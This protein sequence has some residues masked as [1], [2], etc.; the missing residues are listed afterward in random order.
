ML[1]SRQLAIGIASVVAF[2]AALF[3][4]SQAKAEHVSRSC[5]GGDVYVTY[6]R[7]YRTTV[8]YTEPVRR[9]SRSYLRHY[10]KPHRHYYSGHRRHLRPFLRSLVHHAR[11]RHGSH[12]P[13]FRSGRRHH[14]GHGFSFR[15]RR[16]HGGGF[17]RH[18]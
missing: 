8:V 7:A 15:G 6:G 2:A 10:R 9:Y 5:G 13:S 4:G 16:G 14:R 17:R 18:H 1:R 11:H 12:G 3:G